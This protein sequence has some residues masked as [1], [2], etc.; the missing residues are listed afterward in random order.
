MKVTALVT[1]ILV[2]SVHF[3]TMGASLVSAAE[4]GKGEHLVPI[5]TANNTEF[6]FDLY[7]KINENSQGNNVFFS[8][9]S[10]SMALGMTYAGAR[11]ETERQMEKVMHFNLPQDD[12]HIAFSL[13]SERVNASEGKGYKLNIA[14][15]LW[16]Q[17]DY[18]FLNSFLD[19]ANTHYGGGFNVVDFINNPEGSREV[20]NRW[21]ENKT[22]DKIKNLLQQRDITPLTR[23]VLTN[24]IYFKGDWAKKFNKD[25]TRAEDFY[26]NPDYAVS[27]SM[28]RQTGNFR[29]ASVDGVQALEMPYI[30]K[31]LSM[32]ILLPQAGNEK[33]S[34]LF[35]PDLLNN[36]LNTMAEQQVTVSFPKFKFQTRYGLADMLSEMGMPDAFDLPPADF[37]GMTGRMDLYITKVIHQAVIEVNEEGSE[38]AGATAVIMGT[39]SSPK[40]FEFKANR[41]FIFLIRHNTSGSILFLGRLT[42]PASL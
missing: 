27:V 24:A 15:A 20:I 36:I 10:V 4:P 40:I 34:S 2:I 38:A 26:V 14:N 9:F 13:L 32:V 8:P 39:K 6:A 37:S 41:P 18:P 29:Y 7:K 33:F 19:L 1:A 31:E 28:M 21:V 25:D 12:L 42:N 3:L 17:K 30:G 35:T 16:G 5:L 22:N 11:G 23:L